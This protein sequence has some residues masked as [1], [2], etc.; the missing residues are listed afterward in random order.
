MIYIV[1][2]A[3]KITWQHPVKKPQDAWQLPNS[4][5]L[6]NH[7]RGTIEVTP[8]KKVVWHIFDYKKFNSIS[9]IHVLD[10]NGDVT[11]NKIL[12]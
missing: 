8:E 5:I 1:D 12:R 10:I 11:K 4:N 7:L 9:N 6:Y 2:N 3:S